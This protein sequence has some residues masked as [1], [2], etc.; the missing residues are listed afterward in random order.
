MSFTVILYKYTIMMDH[1]FLYFLSFVL[2]GVWY[3]KPEWKIAAIPAFLSLF[4]SLYYIYG[5]EG[6]HLESLKHMGLDLLVLSAHLFILQLFKHF[7]WAILLVLPLGFSMWISHTIVQSSIDVP[8]HPEILIKFKSDDVAK[9]IFDEFGYSIDS[10]ELAFSV[11]DIASTDLDDYYV[12]D[13]KEVVDPS[14]FVQKLKN[15]KNVEWIEENQKVE[16]PELEGLN[17]FADLKSNTFNDPLSGGQWHVDAF[18]ISAMHE[19]LAKSK[20][21]QKKKVTIAILD[22]GVDSK[23][24]DLSAVYKSSGDKKFDSDQKGHGTHCAGIAAAVS[25]NKTGIASILPKNSKIQVMSIQVLNN[26][27]YGTQQTIINGILKA[28]D[29]NADVISLSLGG[30]TSEA[31][32]RAYRRAVDYANEKGSIVVVAAGNSSKNAKNFS[33]A[34]TKGVIAVTAVDEKMNLAVFANTVDDLKMGIAAP[35]VNILST[36]PNNEYKQFSGTSMATPF[37]AGMVALLKSYYPDITTKEAYEKITSG[38]ISIQSSK[39]PI[40]LPD[41]IVD[42]F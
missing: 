26:Y 5:S 29:L 32:E 18:N 22:T 31:K 39:T 16:I 38:S 24:E 11:S 37:V 6:F 8:D 13:L 15:N 7:K 1:L 25:N 3:S 2:F 21:K 9:S 4:A 10:Y 36:V 30:M 12:I 40:M 27:G 23:H 20:T 35:G 33:P 19:K 42:N 28:A 34:N 41:Q 14:K 17:N